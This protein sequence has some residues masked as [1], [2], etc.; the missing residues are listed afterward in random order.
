[1]YFISCSNRLASPL[2]F[3]RRLPVQIESEITY[4]KAL[5]NPES[6]P[7]L[8]EPAECWVIK[9]QNSR[10]QKCGI[11][12]FL[13]YFKSILILLGI[14]HPQGQGSIKK[15]TCQVKFEIFKP[16]DQEAYPYL[17]WVSTGIHTHPPPP[18]IKIPI[19]YCTEIFSIL[20]RINNPTLTTGKCIRN[21]FKIY[22]KYI[23]AGLLKHPDLQAF[24]QKYNG[25]TLSTIH[26]SFANQ[27]KISAMITKW[28][29][30]FYPKG[31]SV[32]AVLHEFEVK[33]KNSPDQ[34]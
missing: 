20:R 31:T 28:R 6:Y 1:L 27:D 29:V 30:G 11:N 4:L 2:H 18:P 8:I 14:D 7:G 34:V 9:Q 12:L 10:S 5:F 3:N 32:P 33:H 13:I 22:S 21:A 16:L 26:K 15:A 24:C 17:I 19:Q 25:Q 23:L